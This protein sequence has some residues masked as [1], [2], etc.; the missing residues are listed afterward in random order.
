MHSLCVNSIIFDTAGMHPINNGICAVLDEHNGRHTHVFL[1]KNIVHKFYDKHCPQFQELSPNYRLAAQSLPG[2]ALYKETEDSRVERLSYSYIEGSTTPRSIQQFVCIL[3]ALCRLHENDYV[4]ADVRQTN[5][6]FSSTD[7]TATI[8]DFDMA[9]KEG[10]WY[11]MIY[12]HIGI[13]ERRP[14]ARACMPRRREHDLVALGVIIERCF[15][16]K[17]LAM[18]LKEREPNIPTILNN[19]QACS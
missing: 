4:H 12:N 8:I 3:Q 13:E 19:L 18:Q 10:A 7:N 2:L 6:M 16:S 5:I 11:P 14:Q 17:E 15:G 9:G 1:D